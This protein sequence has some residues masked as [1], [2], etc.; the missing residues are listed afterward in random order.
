MKQGLGPYLRFYV[1]V[2]RDVL[3][4][5]L[6]EESTL[7]LTTKEDEVFRASME[8]GHKICHIQVCA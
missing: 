6:T 4:Y 8:S 3:A 1:L 7:P 5:P 2:L